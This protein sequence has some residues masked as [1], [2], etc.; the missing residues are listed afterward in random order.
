MAR[1]GYP[2]I[3]SVRTMNVC[4]AASGPLVAFASG[5]RKIIMPGRGKVIGVSLNLQ[6]KGGTHVTSTVDVQDDGV[7][8]LTAPFNV[9]T[10][11]AG[12]PQSKE[13]SPGGTGL[14]AAAD[15]VRKDSVIS[16][17]MAEAGGTAPTFQ[18]ADLQID[19]MPLAD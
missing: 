7:S 3:H 10:A 11:V 12:T 18:G 6:G 8:I 9:A 13:A 1:N 15:D 5:T 19:W 16:I 4:L 2:V 17:I 14:A